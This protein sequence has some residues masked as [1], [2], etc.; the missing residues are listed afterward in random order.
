MSDRSS[1][2]QLPYLAA[3][4]AQKHVTVNE[5]LQRLDAVVQL[6]AVSATIAA[7]PE[8]PVDGAVYIVP[9]GKT[10][11]DWDAMTNGALAYYRDGA[12]EEVAP[13]EGWLAFVADQARVLFFAGAAWAPL[14][15]ATQ[16][17]RVLAAS[18]VA[19]SHTGDTNET[20]LATVLIPAGAM[21][22]NGVL[23]VTSVWSYTNSANTKVLRLRLGGAAGS[24]FQSVAVTTTASLRHEVQICNRGV[25][26]AQ[27][28]QPGTG[29]FGASSS[30]P[31]TGAIDTSANQDLVFRALLTNSGE[32][33]TLE[34]YLVELSYNA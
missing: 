32:T 4:Q 2:L 1:N 27:L 13:R 29:A 33:V 11:A 30:A 14:A 17:W 26:N 22:P 8:S 12:W 21:G 5:S 19:A 16:G 6:A 15:H 9:S 28:G 20:T 25:Q 3:G 10:G 18:G 31:S 34:S 24:L 7:Q 23:R